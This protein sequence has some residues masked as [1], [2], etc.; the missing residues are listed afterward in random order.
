MLCLCPTQARVRVSTTARRMLSESEPGGQS[1]HDPNGE[2][3]QRDILIHEQVAITV[4]ERGS[5]RRGTPTSHQVPAAA[6]PPCADRTAH[7]AVG[8]V[9]RVPRLMPRE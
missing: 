9:W 4:D 7:I 3:Q 8:R 2:D 1:D 6:A 5:H